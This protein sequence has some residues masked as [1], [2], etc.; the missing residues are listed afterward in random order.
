MIQ[1]K[2]ELDARGRTR[3]RWNCGGVP[4]PPDSEHSFCCLGKLGQPSAFEFELTRKSAQ[5]VALPSP[6]LHT[7]HKDKK[8]QDQVDGP[9]QQTMDNQM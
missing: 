4:L 7:T 2:R 9:D 5:T 3:S 6:E 1:E 8:K